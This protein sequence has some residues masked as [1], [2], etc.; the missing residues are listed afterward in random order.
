MPGHD[1]SY[2]GINSATPDTPKS[3]TR[4]LR[5]LSVCR[6]L[7][8]EYQYCNMMYTAAS[9]IVEVL[10]GEQFAEFLQSRIWDP[11]QMSNGSD[12]FGLEPIWSSRTD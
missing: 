10:N 6:P 11:L 12:L 8:S 9:C 1:E 2:L 3:V 4:N 5:N 7:R